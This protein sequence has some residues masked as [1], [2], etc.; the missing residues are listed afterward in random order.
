MYNNS[1][2]SN[3]GNNFEN[4]DVQTGLMEQKNI[5][6]NG[7]Y[8]AEVSG[9]Y[10]EFTIASVFKSLPDEYDIMNDILIQTGVQYKRYSLQEYQMNG[11]PVWDL[12]IRTGKKEYKKLEKEVGIQM[13]LRGQPIYEGIKKSSQIDHMIVSPYGIFVIETKNHK[14]FIFGDMQSRVWTQVLKGEKGGKVYGNRSHYTFLNPALQNELH[15]QHLNKEWK[16]PRNVMTG[17]V[18]FT[19]PDADL[20]NVSCPCCYTV[21][22]LAMAILSYQK[23]IFTLKKKDRI[24]EMIDKRNSSSYLAEK[25]HINYVKTKQKRNN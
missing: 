15:L 16:I 11:T 24:V 25:E 13:L 9:M 6:T 18:V 3:L 5:K 2:R 17:M 23:Q 8:Q 12:Y 7:S 14:G 10:G 19:S 1:W 4:S 22:T 20:S 21:D